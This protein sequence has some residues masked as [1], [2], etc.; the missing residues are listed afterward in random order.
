MTSERQRSPRPLVALASLIVLV[1]AL[2][3]PLRPASAQEPNAFVGGIPGAGVSLAVYGG[4]PVS[5]LP[6]AAPA[7][8][9]FWTTISGE[10]VGYLVGSP[11]FVNQPF[12]D[13]FGETIP[14][15]TPLIVVTPGTAAGPPLVSDCPAWPSDALA[16]IANNERAESIYENVLTEEQRDCFRGLVYYP[17]DNAY[18]ITAT[19][20]LVPDDERATPV[21]IPT[22]GTHLALFMPWAR[23]QFEV[24]GHP[25]TLMIV[26][27]PQDGS[28]FL[29]FRDA[30]C[31][32]TTYGGG[33]YLGVGR[34]ENGDVYIDLNHASNP[35]CAYN[36]NWTCPLVHPENTLDFAVEAG[37]RAYPDPR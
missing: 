23:I 14:A 1:S 27:R 29:S 2:A 16:V 33:R 36:S 15:G 25:A 12:I 10:L 26:Q 28:L 4:G 18:R 9:S 20:E 5:E 13:R 3:F 6:L 7:A 35:P 17:Q 22:S 24:N 32:N 34:Y 19:P 11:S 37:E 30:T 8:T 21:Y 31:G